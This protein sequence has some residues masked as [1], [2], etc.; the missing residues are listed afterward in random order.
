MFKKSRHYDATALGL[1][2]ALY[3]ILILFS[4]AVGQGTAVITCG[5]RPRRK[6][7]P[8]YHP[9]GQALDIRVKDKPEWWIEAVILIIRAFKMYDDRIQYKVHGEG[10]HRH[11]H[12]QFKKGKPV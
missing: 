11:I 6:G 12:I 2:T 8:S 3:C 5:W 9:K 1:F 4:E 7:K 10:V